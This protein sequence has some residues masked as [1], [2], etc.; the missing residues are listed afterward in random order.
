MNNVANE[1][2]K[3]TKLLKRLNNLAVDMESAR[4]RHTRAQC[5]L[6]TATEA[7]AE[8]ERRLR[9]QMEAELLQMEAELQE[10]LSVLVKAQ[11]SAKS[12]VGTAGKLYDNLQGKHD[13]ALVRMQT[14]L[15][16][17]AVAAADRELP[18]FDTHAPVA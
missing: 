13:S 14:L 8:E 5:E 11:N 7:L 18:V 2:E 16:D 4:L 15:Q 1:C 3:R 10:Q 12:E 9:L 6:G 17:T